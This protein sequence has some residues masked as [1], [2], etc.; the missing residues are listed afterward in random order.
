MAKA[1]VW[2]HLYNMGAQLVP[3]ASPEITVGRGQAWQPPL[4]FHYGR[5]LSFKKINL[6]R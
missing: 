2:D 1:G 3:C 6:M 4:I 5:F